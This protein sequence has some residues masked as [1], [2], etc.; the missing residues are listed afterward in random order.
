LSELMEGLDVATFSPHLDGGL[1]L[2]SAQRP[3]VTDRLAIN[4]GP[5]L[6]PDWY[7]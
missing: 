1:M 5:V 7:K 4:D 6:R 2:Q 3:C